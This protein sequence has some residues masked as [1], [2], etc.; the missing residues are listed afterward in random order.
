VTSKRKATRKRSGN[1]PSQAG[2]LEALIL[3]AEMIRDELQRSIDVVRKIRDQM[4][5]HVQARDEADRL[6]RQSKQL[7]EESRRYLKQ[8]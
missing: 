6:I 1:P 5:P 2:S 4:S 7:I 3:R 8:S